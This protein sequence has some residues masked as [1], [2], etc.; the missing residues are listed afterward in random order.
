MNLLTKGEA[1]RGISQ[2]IRSTVNDL[3][4]TYQATSPEAW[5]KLQRI[6][7]LSP[8]DLA[9]AFDELATL[10]F[11]NKNAM[12]AVAK[13]NFNVLAGNW[14]DLLAAGLAAKVLAGETTYYNKPIDDDVV[15]LYERLIRHAR[16]VLVNQLRGSSRC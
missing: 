6:T 2:L 7:G 15:N 4:A 16:S 11:P 8:P 10:Q 14:D 9:R 13:D 1:T 5:K 12:K 3:Y